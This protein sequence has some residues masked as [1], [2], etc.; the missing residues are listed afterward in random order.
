MDDARLHSRSDGDISLVHPAKVPKRLPPVG[1]VLG[2]VVGSGVGLDGDSK[3][4]PAL[5][6][7]PVVLDGV[8]DGCGGWEVEGADVGVHQSGGLS[9]VDHVVDEVADER[10]RARV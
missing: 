1:A 5:A 6:L 7:A 2:D 8:R 3:V 9:L 10:P 4:A